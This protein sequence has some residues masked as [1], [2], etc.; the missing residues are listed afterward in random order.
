MI[1]RVTRLRLKL[2][3]L[4]AAAQAWRGLPHAS[5]AQGGAGSLLLVDSQTGEALNIGLFDSREAME[6]RNQVYQQNAAALADFI[7]S[8]PSVQVFE[9]LGRSG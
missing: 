3:Q 4:Q 1:A 8:A 6:A 7:A 5:Q 2:D 9:V